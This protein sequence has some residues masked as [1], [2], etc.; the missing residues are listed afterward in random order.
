MRRGASVLLL[1][2]VAVA[3]LLFWR[4]YGRAVPRNDVTPLAPLAVDRNQVAEHLA[5]AVRART[6]FGFIEADAGAGQFSALHQSLQ[7]AFPRVFATLHI[8]R[9]NRHGLLLTWPGSERALAPV[10]MLAHQDVV[11]IA[12]G[13]ESLWR[14]P[15]FVGARA[16]GMVW[17]RGAWDN[18][19]NL[20]ALLQAV[21]TLL[22]TGHAPRRGL[23]IALTHDEEV[24]SRDAEAL[25]RLLGQRGVRPAFILDEGLLITEGVIHGLAKPL[26][27]IGI[28][29][30][31]YLSVRLRTRATPGHS[32]MPP[33]PGQSALARLARALDRIEHRQ[34]APHLSNVA[35]QM[36]ETL[37]PQMPAAQRLALSNLWLFAPL[38]ARQLDAQGGGSAAMLRTTAALTVAQAGGKDNVLPAQAEATINLRLLPGDRIDQALDRLRRAVD[39][40]EVE[41]LPLRHE[42]QEASEV[43]SIDG[44]GYRL[45]EVTIKEVFPG[46]LVAPGLMVGATDSRKLGELA[47]PTY[48]FS[49]IRAG[50]QELARFHGTDE[51]I[52]EDNLVEM[53]RFYHRLVAQATGGALDA[54]LDRP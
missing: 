15:P 25:A 5:A 21:E 4:A 9:L 8:E 23:L 38:V 47:A 44:A 51:R 13:S 45:L 3:S 53:V 18:K 7:R 48:R 6:V 37:A 54:G 34:A 20:I 12:P 28:A 14:H 1:A 46:T 22:S 10:L 11:P 19:S 24:G 43:S 36:L 49:P 41:M 31:G 40:P 50:P 29:E 35:R 16:D 39:D 17:G 27:L 2:V 33:P 52:G 26:A 42:A 32:S 30:K